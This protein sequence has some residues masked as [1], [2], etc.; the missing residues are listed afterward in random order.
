MTIAQANRLGVI[1]KLVQNSIHRANR[2]LQ[3]LHEGAS[4]HADRVL[5]ADVFEKL[6]SAYRDA[7][8][9]KLTEYVLLQILC[10]P[11]Q[12]QSSARA[13]GRALREIDYIGLLEDGNL[14]VL[15]S[16][17]DHAAGAF[18]QQKIEKLGV[19]TRVIEES[20]L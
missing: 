2:Y 7:G 4:L 18:V 14:Y 17:T 20:E 9:R 16:S 6:V 1:G 11:P 8:S 19:N 3:S 13:V 15:L 5:R 12:Q 10:T